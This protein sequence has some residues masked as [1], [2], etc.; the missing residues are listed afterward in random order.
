MRDPGLRTQ[1]K[2]ELQ[3]GALVLVSIIV[4]VWGMVWITS[5]GIG[6]GGF[7]FH[8]FTP[9]AQQ[10]TAG[11]RVFL[12]G[13]D[14]GSVQR[15]G[16]AEGGVLLDVSVSPQVSIPVDSK[17]SIQS[18]GFLGSQT[19]VLVPGHASGRLAAGDTIAAAPAAGLTAMASSLGED[20]QSVLDRTKRLLADSAIDAMHSTARD[21]S[22]TMHDLR[23]LVDSERATLG[24]LIESLESTSSQLSSATSGPELRETLVRLDS[25]TGRLHETSRGLDASSR[26]LASILDKVDSGEGSLGKLV[27]DENLYDK[28]TAAAENLQSASEEIALLTRDI[29]ERP[30]RYLKG[31]KFSVF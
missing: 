2:A 30:E 14:V 7:S 22:G 19:V 8:V 4:L 24:R 21:L 27:N 16:L 10:V 26:S 12:H 29:R 17:A 25:L 3:V 18:A 15:V 20:A 5:S 23:G 28:V 1:H 6:R 11:D 9:D 31:L 13:V